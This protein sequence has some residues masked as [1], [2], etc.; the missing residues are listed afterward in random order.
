MSLL[1]FFLLLSIF[2]L[3][4]LTSIQVNLEV[5]VCHVCMSANDITWCS[6]PQDSVLFH[7]CSSW[8]CNANEDWARSYI[9][10]IEC[11]WSKVEH[12]R[13][14]GKSSTRGGKY[15]F[16]LFFLFFYF[17]SLDHQYQQH[18]TLSSLILISLYMSIFYFSPPSHSITFFLTWL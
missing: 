6:P 4:V 8:W 15:F 12:A 14:S 3:L 11:L 13:V 7:S 18:P 10:C 17:F 5:S 1:L 2:P 16:N 9:L